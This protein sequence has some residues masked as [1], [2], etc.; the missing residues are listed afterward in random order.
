MSIAFPVEVF[1][2]LEMRFDDATTKTGI[3]LQGLR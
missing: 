2:D 3:S 1:H